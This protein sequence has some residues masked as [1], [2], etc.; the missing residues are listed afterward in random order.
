MQLPTL[1]LRCVKLTVLD[2]D[3]H[4]ISIGTG[5]IRS[6]SNGN[7]LYT[8]WHLVTGYQPHNLEFRLPPPGRYLTILMQDLNIDEDNNSHTISGSRDFT[9]FLYDE[10]SEQGRPLWLQ[11]EDHIPNADLN[12]IGIYVPFFHDVVK[13]RLPDDKKISFAQSI[14]DE[15]IKYFMPVYLGEKCLIVGFPYGYS[16]AGPDQPSPVVLTRFIAAT[17]VGGRRQNLLLDGTGANGMSGGPVFKEYEGRLYLF[18]IYTG[19]IYPDHVIKENDKT[20]ALGTID[21]LT[22]VF[23]NVK[24]LVPIPLTALTREGVPVVVDPD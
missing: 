24:Q 15:D 16:T 19:L 22:L 20:T 10:S 5:F 12:K 8:C 3:K 23:S 1:P 11:D 4:A 6:E 18:G 2:H 9:I 17:H 21:D 13:I 7:Y 14:P